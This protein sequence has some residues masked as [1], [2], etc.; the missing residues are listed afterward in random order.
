M[1]DAVANGE[2]KPAKSRKS[3]M[4]V[5]LIL[6]LVGG[7]AGFYAMKSGLIPLGHQAAEGDMTGTGPESHG[8]AGDPE[9]SGS[10]MMAGSDNKTVMDDIAFV[11]IDPI[12][13]SMMPGQSVSFLRF[14]AQLEVNSEYEREVSMILP[15][16]TDVLNGYLRALELKDLTGPLALVRLR[17]QMLRRVQIVTGRG[18]VR[19]LLIMEFVLN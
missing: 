5:A 16:V 18:R 11:E 8:G 15:R 14:R 17:S 1:T 4:L 6:A 13:I 7:G 2:E 9:Y 19:D 12:T 3:S 10:E